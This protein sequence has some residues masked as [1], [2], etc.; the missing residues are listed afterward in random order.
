MDKAIQTN[1]ITAVVTAGVLGI[2]GW[3]GGVFEAGS[4]AL[5]EQQIEAVIKRVLVMD[6][7][8]TFAQ[9]LN[10]LNNTSIA[11]NTTVTELTKEVDDLEVAVLALAAE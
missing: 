9:A 10:S 2:L 1:V 5:D 3:A 6:S 8:Q 11:L 4:T 7:G